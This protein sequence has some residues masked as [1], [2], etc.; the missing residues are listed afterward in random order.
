[1]KS[2]FLLSLVLLLAFSAAIF[3]KDVLRTQAEKVAVN[4]FFE[5]SHTFGQA[6]DYLDI[7]IIDSYKVDNAYYV[8]NF[9]DGWVLVSA[10]DVT[11]PVLGYNVTGSFPSHQDQSDNIRNWMQHFT[12]QVVFINENN[13]RAS[14]EASAD[15]DKYQ[16]DEYELL[17]T[18]NRDV[19][20]PLLSSKWNQ[21]NPYNLLC[22]EDEEGPGGHVY[23]GCVATAMSMIMHY[24][25]YPA[26]GTGTHS[27]NHYPYGTITADFGAAN[28]EWNAMQ[29]EIDNNNPME[30]AEIGFHAGVS[31]EMM[32]SGDGSGAYSFDVPAALKTYFGYS[33]QTQHISKSSYSTAQWE[34]FLQDE[35]DAGHPVYYSGQSSTGG[36][37]FGCDGYEGS[38]YYH[39]NFGW[40]GSGNGFYSLQDV[41]GFSGGQAMVRNIVPAD[42]NYPYIS[43]G[44]TTLAFSSGSFTDGSGPVENY[45]TGMD[46]SWLISPQT[47]MD[48]IESISLSFIEFETDASDVLRI[49]EGDD[50]SGTLIGE[51]S[52]NELPSQINYDGNEMFITFTSTGTNKGFK[53]EYTAA[54]PKWCSGSQTFTEQSGSFSDGSHDFYYNNGATCVYV[55]QNPEAVKFNLEFTEF[56]TEAN[57]DKVT[58]YN[59]SN[60]QVAEYSGEEIPEPLSVETNALFIT[61]STNTSI[62]GLGWSAEYF[63]DGVGI[64]EKIGD[65]ENVTVYPNPSSG[66][67]NVNFDIE[68]AGTLEIKLIN[69]N[70]QIIKNETINNFDGQFNRSFDLSNQ[71]KGIYMLSIMSKKGKIDKKIVLR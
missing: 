8:I 40:S 57:H 48:S 43:S 37:A 17:L 12:D 7:N 20:T 6:T 59:G 9:E 46:A 71:A 54:S 41:N 2:K 26:T 47:E 15:W 13:V 21:N 25:R 56:S 31:V 58:V 53:I 27:Y 33:T 14:L 68:D 67:L 63:I 62:R 36:H 16:T 11:E 55:I 4:F 64:E 22:P 50:A 29:D 34:N 32:Y 49:Y 51:F 60:Q 45:P 24:W 1:M 35:F 23:V 19:T 18:G 3:A 10:N 5:K 38:N 28:Y 39:F 66:M 61:W 30:M 44:A 70:G 42:A 52:G 69:L 65:Y